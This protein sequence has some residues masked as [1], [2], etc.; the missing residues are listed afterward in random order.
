MR[1]AEPTYLH[2]K[3]GMWDTTALNRPAFVG[4]WKFS[5]EMASHHLQHL[6]RSFEFLD[7][8]GH[9]RTR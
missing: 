2:R 1:L 7:R 8:P 5:S 6:F 3:S 4:N 9:F